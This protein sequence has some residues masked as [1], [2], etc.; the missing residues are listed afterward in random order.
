MTPFFDKEKMA[1]GSGALVDEGDH[2]FWF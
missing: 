1:V 2:I